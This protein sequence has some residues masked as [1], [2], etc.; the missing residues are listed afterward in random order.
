MGSAGAQAVNLSLEGA[1]PALLEV[2]DV[3]GRRVWSHDIGGLGAGKHEVRLGDGERYP[4]GVYM[5]RLTQ[6]SHV[7]RA[8]VAVID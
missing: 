4:S 6:G 3:G 8:H 1:S 7:V 2:F 5:V